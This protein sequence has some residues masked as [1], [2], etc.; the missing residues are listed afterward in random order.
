MATGRS[1]HD[2][3]LI[4]GKEFP[5]CFRSVSILWRKCFL[6]QL[7]GDPSAIHAAYRW[8]ICIGFFFFFFTFLFV[9]DAN[10]LCTDIC[11]GCLWRRSCHEV[12][13]FHVRLRA[14]FQMCLW[15]QEHT[16]DSYTQPVERQ[17]IPWIVEVWCL[18]L[19]T[20]KT[21]TNKFW[22]FAYVPTPVIY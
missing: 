21:N 16:E 3:L 19:L 11:P 17:T 18:G 14:S 1:S 9:T 6:I 20:F 12:H 10:F 4:M 13:C 22:N 5:T 7:S 2:S 15:V 8:N